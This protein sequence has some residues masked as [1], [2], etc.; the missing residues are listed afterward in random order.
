[1]IAQGITIAMG[2]GS[3]AVLGRLLTPGDFGIVSI[4]SAF[5]AFVTMFPEQGLPQAIVQRAG[6]DDR[7][8]NA[9]FWINVGAGLFA[10][11]LGILAAWPISIWFGRPELFGV[12]VV[13]AGTMVASGLGSPHAAILRRSLRF[14]THSTI[15]VVA[16]L[17]GLIVGIS[18][19]IA[20]WNY[21]SLV[22]MTASMTIAR[23]VG[24]WTCSGWRPGRPALAEGIGPMVRMAAYL[25]ATSL[26]TT[27]SRTVDRILIGYGLGDAA[28]GY[29]S[30][31]NRLI[32]VPTKQL[33]A[34]V[35]SVAIPILSRIQGTP[36]RFRAFYR[37]GLEAVVFLL[38]PFVVVAMVTADHLVPLFL[39]DQWSDSIPIFLALTPAALAACT[40]VATSWVY[41]P[42]GHT[43]RQFRWRILA[44]I[45]MVVSFFIGL[46][47][48]AVGVAAAFSIQA[49]L[50]RIPAIAYCIHGTFIQGSDILASIWRTGMAV[51]ITMLAGWWIHD[52]IPPQWDHLPA[53]IVMASAVFA[54]YLAAFG[55][56]PGGPARLRGMVELTRHL[57]AERSDEKQS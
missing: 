54:V 46:Q 42:L 41:I 12:I 16:N 49:L 8:L 30:N 13:L 1:M 36:E 25:G 35:T 23:M 5:M 21:W 26:L 37:T 33:N 40:R 24:M 34:P 53:C 32:L 14:R 43:D 4:A 45:V 11:C 28:A 20:S 18:T 52:A 29:Y 48:G 22:A 39:G 2:I 51:A 56:T 44:S 31:A 15:G 57:R 38:C 6:L 9:L 17:I 10:A 27:A 50:M 7:Q 55:L 47:W 3:M 19:A